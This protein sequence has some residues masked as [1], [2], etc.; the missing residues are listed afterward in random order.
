MLRTHDKS[1]A[2]QDWL[3]GSPLCPGLLPPPEMQQTF[4]RLGADWAPSVRRPMAKG[5]PGYYRQMEL[6]HFSGPSPFEDGAR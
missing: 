4:P 1:M 5:G 3:L 2:L 6:L